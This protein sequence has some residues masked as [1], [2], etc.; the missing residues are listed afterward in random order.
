MLGIYVFGLIKPI[1]PIIKDVIAHAFFKTSHE[2]SIHYENGKYHMHIE[3]QQEAQKTDSER[4]S[5]VSENDFLL[6][7]IKT[8]AVTFSFYNQTISEINSPY[9][10]S[11][12]DIFIPTVLLP[13]EC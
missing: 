7:H 1:T 4:A 2:A 3:L 9:L 5:T 8:E 11:T 6:T 13:P 12:Q 10:N